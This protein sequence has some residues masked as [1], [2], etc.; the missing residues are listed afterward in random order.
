MKLTISHDTNVEAEI[1]VRRTDAL[2]FY[3]GTSAHAA[4][5]II[6][7]G[8]RDMFAELKLR[9]LAK[10]IW[11]VALEKAG[12]RDLTA[13]LF[14]QA[15]CADP[16][17]VSLLL[18][19]A[20]SGNQNGLLLYGAFYVSMNFRTACDYALRSSTGSECLTMIF[21]GM[22]LLDHLNSP[23]KDCIRR[24][25]PEAMKAMTTQSHP[26]V[27]E[28]IGI[29]ETRIAREDGNPDCWPKILLAQ[30]PAREGVY[31]PAPFRIGN[32]RSSDIV[33]VHDLRNWPLA[34]FSDR[35]WRPAQEDEAVRCSAKAWQ[36]IQGG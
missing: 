10:Q 19:D 2:S 31:F 24:N 14:E 29:D 28:L 32:V 4:A 22:K 6:D 13:E 23:A 1:F 26:V 33:W 25:Y 7:R 5:G 11:D 16:V 9:N 34:N 18:E 17:G 35:S 20:S 3:H 21:E 30:R 27:I 12:S 36:H 8:A 15:G